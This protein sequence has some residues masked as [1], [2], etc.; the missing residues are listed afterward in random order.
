MLLAEVVVVVEDQQAYSGLVLALVA[1]YHH[2]L[3]HVLDFCLVLV[4]VALVENRVFSLS[5]VAS[6]M[7]GNCFYRHT[8]VLLIG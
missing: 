2:L 3:V 4:V 6:E 1:H 7:V 8:R 5:L